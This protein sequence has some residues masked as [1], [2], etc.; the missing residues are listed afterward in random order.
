MSKQFLW[1]DLDLAK[2]P[3]RSHASRSAHDSCLPGWTSPDIGKEPALSFKCH[4]FRIAGIPIQVLD[5]ADSQ[6]AE[7]VALELQRDFYELNKI[8]FANADIVIDIGGHIGL[9][10]IFLALRFPDIVI[11]SFEPFPENSDLFR[12]NLALNSVNNVQL[13]PM[14]VSGDGRF[15]E[16]VTNPRNSGGATCN[17]QTLSHCRTNMIPS[18]TLDNVFNS[19]GI[20]CCKLLK[21]DCE[22]S[23]YEVLLSTHN[24]SRVKY[25][26]GEFHTNAFLASQGYSIEQLRVYCETFLTSDRIA[27][28]SCRMSE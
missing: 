13:H 25:L 7:L 5:S 10:S 12:R 19:L 6:A 27:V 8:Q 16:M 22:G 24:L 14:A 4:R 9:F 18:T 11:H 23:E 15:L 3:L 21:I 26:C 2:P 28:R 20:Q 17:S 1:K